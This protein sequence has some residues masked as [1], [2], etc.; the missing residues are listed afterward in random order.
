MP[1]AVRCLS[2]CVYIYQ[3][4]TLIRGGSSPY[5]GRNLPVSGP[6]LSHTFSLSCSLSLSLFLSLSLSCHKRPTYQSKRRANHKQCVHE[7]ED[8]CIPEQA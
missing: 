1:L 7:E 3:K 8:T 6:S 2:V 4:S 5:L